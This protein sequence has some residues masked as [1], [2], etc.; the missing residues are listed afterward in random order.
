MLGT[1]AQPYDAGPPG[2]LCPQT[3]IATQDALTAI[4]TIPIQDTI[5][6]A[7]KHIIPVSIIILK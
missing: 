5:E 4:S 3:L 1:E 2:P 7:L 6:L